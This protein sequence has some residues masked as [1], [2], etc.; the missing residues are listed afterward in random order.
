MTVKVAKVVKNGVL[1]YA[2]E[3]GHY[4][5]KIRTVTGG[6]DYKCNCEDQVF[7]GPRECKHITEFKKAEAAQGI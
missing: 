5:T 4:V 1:A 7:R 2:V 6:V 3:N